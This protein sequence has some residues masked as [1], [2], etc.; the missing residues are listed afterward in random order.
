MKHTAVVALVLALPLMAGAQV[1]RCKDPATGKYLYTDQPCKGGELVVPQ[2]TEEDLR[3]EAEAAALARERQAAQRA[4][5][6][7]QT[8]RDAA[9][10]QL[11]NRP[12]AQPPAESADCRKARA[13]ADFRAR[14][15]TATEEQVRTARYNA[16]LT[17]GQTPPPEIVVAPPEPWGAVPP[18][19]RRPPR[20][21]PGDGAGWQ[22]SPSPM[23]RP[24]R[25]ESYPVLPRSPSAQPRP[26]PSKPQSTGMSSGR[27][28]MGTEEGIPL[29]PHTL[30]R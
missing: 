4:A 30:S 9:R 25:E 3:H 10:A 12:T 29:A 24:P 1:I 17:C 27:V 21:L 20:P 7:E 2:R 15:N 13:E 19:H 5:E 18:V 14:S 8:Q 22:P 28:T 26:L 23:P 16:A 11:A 6:R